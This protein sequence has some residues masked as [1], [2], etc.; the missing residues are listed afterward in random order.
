MAKYRYFP[1]CLYNINIA[2]K[3][4]YPGIA[5]VVFEIAPEGGL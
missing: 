1:L 5:H 3:Y 2:T 4:E